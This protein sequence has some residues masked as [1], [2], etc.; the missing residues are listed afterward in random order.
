MSQREV[1]CF[2]KKFSKSSGKFYLEASFN[3]LLRILLSQWTL[4]F[5]RETKT[6]K[7][8]SR[9]K[10][11]RE[12]KDEIWP[13]NGRPGRDFTKTDS[14]HAFGSKL[15]KVISKD[16]ERKVTLQTRYC[17]RHALSLISRPLGGAQC[18]WRHKS[19]IV[20]LFSLQFKRK[21]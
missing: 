4:S 12:H 10:C 20:A 15:C 21:S 5:N 6:A 3:Y 18:C 14:R 8:M 2:L 13:A 16:V 11:F 9:L 7:T 19:H 17:L 1:S